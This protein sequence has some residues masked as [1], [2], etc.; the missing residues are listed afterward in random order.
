MILVS[1]D[2]WSLYKMCFSITEVVDEAIYGG[3]YIQVV[4][5]IGGL[6]IQVVFIYRWSLC[7]GGL[8]IQ[9][10]FIYRWSLYK[11]GLYIQVVFI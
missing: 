7:K 5:Y 3:L 11:G 10:V 2:R 9:V 4:L 8:Y 6:Y 1:V